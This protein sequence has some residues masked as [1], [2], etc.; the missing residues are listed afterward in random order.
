MKT[1]CIATSKCIELNPVVEV[2]KIYEFLM[3]PTKV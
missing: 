1:G 3:N 2:P